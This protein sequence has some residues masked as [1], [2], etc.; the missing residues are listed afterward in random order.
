MSDC[1]TGSSRLPS[2]LAEGDSIIHKTGTGFSTE[3]GVSAINDAGIIIHP[4]GNYC[5]AVVF[6]LNYPDGVDAAERLLVKTIA[7]FLEK[8]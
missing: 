8:H 2:I 5:I 1:K 3:K 7:E 4:D 6:V